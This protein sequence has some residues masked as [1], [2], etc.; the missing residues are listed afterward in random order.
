MGTTSDSL[1]KY[2]PACNNLYP[3]TATSVRLFV[4]R[5]AAVRLSLTAL[6]VFN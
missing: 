4:P 1:S 3:M 2:R 5:G 6:P